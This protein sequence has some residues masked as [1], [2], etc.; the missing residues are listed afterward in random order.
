M[1]V[2]RKTGTGKA[3]I[4]VRWIVIDKG[5]DENPDYLS[6]VVAEEMN[7][8]RRNDTFSSRPALEALK[9]RLPF[10]VTKGIGDGKKH[11]FHRRYL[12][13]G[14]P[15]APWEAELLKLSARVRGRI[16]NLLASCGAALPWRAGREVLGFEI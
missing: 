15:P 1:S 10:A 14:T 11:R 13:N 5:D 9:L 8:R 12:S 2:G 16:L 6:R 4:K 7:N 3:P